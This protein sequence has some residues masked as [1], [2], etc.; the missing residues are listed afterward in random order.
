MR[1]DERIGNL[2]QQRFLAISLD[3]RMVTGQK[4]RKDGPKVPLLSGG[5]EKRTTE[6]EIISSEKG[7]L[8]EVL[9]GNGPEFPGVLDI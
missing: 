4:T 8:V 1:L 6:G 7:S 9:C 2:G 3:N 5:P